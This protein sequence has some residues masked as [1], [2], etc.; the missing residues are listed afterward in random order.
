MAMDPNLDQ[1]EA[2]AEALGPLMDE[3]CLVGGCAAGLLVS[4]PGASPIRPTEDVDLVVEAVHYAGYHE[5]C[6]RILARGFSQHTD[7]DDP[8]CRF[9][10]SGLVVDIMPLNEQI[11]GF[12]NR[13][14]M[15]AFEGR[16]RASLPRGALI[17]H[18]D[19]PHLL[20]TK[21]SAFEGRGGGDYVMSHDLE[22]IVRV[23]DGRPEV[24]AEVAASSPDLRAHIATGIRA[25]RADRLFAEAFPAYFEDGPE[26]ARIVDKRLKSLCQAD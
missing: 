24:V 17:H 22:D 3:L 10:S 1:L 16:Q 13:W 15:S 25:F 2:V 8:I 7:G 5:F 19:A 18:I 20:A 6:Q 12:S 11:L 21:L 14:Y 9:R 26:R 23:V 4:D